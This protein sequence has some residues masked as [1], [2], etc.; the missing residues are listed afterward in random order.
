MLFILG[1]GSVVALQNVVVTVICDQFPSLKYGRVAAI[2]SVLGFFSGLIYLTPVCINC[3][4]NVCLCLT[5][6][7][8]PQGG[9]WM[10]A[11]VDNFGG[12]LPI[13]VLAIF[14]IVAIFYFYGLENLCNDVEFM[15][16]RHVTFYWRIC[17]L[18]LAP[19]I[20]TIVYVYSSITMK[21]LQYSGLDYPIAYLYGGWAIFLLALLQL[22]ICFFW[23][24]LRSPK[25]ARQ[26]FVASFQPT[27]LWGP[28]RPN[29]RND[30]L[31]YRE[32][33]R[34]RSRTL[35]SASGHSKLKQSIYLAFGKY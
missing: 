23:E 34:Q 20:M 26:A 28:R 15:T 22:P 2:T 4:F 7:S 29:D 3:R 33:A 32:E 21:P 16:S 13:F 9:Q 27:A 31:K 17:W 30:W 19:V 10:T 12:T 24:F 8:F 18:V 5:Y 6:A 25:P 11:L 14:E 35:A 1:I